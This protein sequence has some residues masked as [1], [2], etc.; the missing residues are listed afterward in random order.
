MTKAF[1]YF[2]HTPKG[3]KFIPSY[4][5]KPMGEPKKLI[6]ANDKN[7]EAVQAVLN[8]MI[9]TVKQMGG[10]N[11][12]KR[13]D[14]EKVVATLNKGPVPLVGVFVKRLIYLKK[15]T[16]FGERIL[17]EFMDQKET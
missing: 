13:P 14:M 17:I 15:T 12:K 16:E 11:P 6:A 3:V 1:I 4:E 5:L 9:G 7:G 8:A 10:F 2:H